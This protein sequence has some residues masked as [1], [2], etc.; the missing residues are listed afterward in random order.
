MHL[1]VQA[2]ALDHVAAVGLQAAPVVAQFDAG[3][4]GDQ[5]IGDLRWNLAQEQAVLAV[6]APAGDEVEILVEQAGHHARDVDRVVLQVAVHGH[7]HVAARRVE[8][9]LHGG[10]LFEVAGQFDDTDVRAVFTGALQAAIHRRIAAA[11]IDQHQFP[12]VLVAGQCLVHPLDQRRDVVFL[13]V[14]RDDDG[15]AVRRNRKGGSHGQVRRESRHF[16]L[17]GFFGHDSDA[18]GRCRRR[19]IPVHKV[20]SKAYKT[21]KESTACC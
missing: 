4:A 10:R 15:Q 17:N 21:G 16:N 3:H 7:D 8:A 2:H 11:V 9:G 20:E 12:G 13:V 5:A 6:L 14:E 19:R 1:A 18:T